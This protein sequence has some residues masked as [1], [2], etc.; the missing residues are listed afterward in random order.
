[1]TTL[2]SERSWLLDRHNLKLVQ[3]CCRLIESEFGV[4]LHLT[5]EHLE[6]KLAAY[7]RKT[8]NTQLH[9]IWECLL[10]QV[11]DLEE[12]T[13]EHPKKLYRGQVVADDRPKAQEREAGQEAHPP[14]KKQIIYRGQV[15]G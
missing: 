1:M 14:R 6:Q 15:I 7:A 5:E 3:Q 13:E 2:L 9:H 12:K 4:R 10:T 11:P 8:Q